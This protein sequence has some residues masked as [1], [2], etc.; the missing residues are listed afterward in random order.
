MFQNYGDVALEDMVNGYGGDGE[1]GLGVLGGFFP[2]LM[3]LWFY[4]NSVSVWFC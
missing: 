3:T 2:T 1:V 4:E